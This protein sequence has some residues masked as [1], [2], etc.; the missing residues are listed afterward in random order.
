MTHLSTTDRLYAWPAR[1]RQRAIFAILAIGMSGSAIAICAPNVPA[2]S[3]SV[4]AL[5]AILL[6]VAAY[7]DCTRLLIPNWLT[8]TIAIY[9]IL[10]NGLA[11]LTHFDSATV[12]AAGMIGLQESVCGVVACFIVMLPLYCAGIGAGDLKLAVALGTLVGPWLGVS[13]IVW[14][15]ILAGAV[16]LLVLGLRQMFPFAANKLAVVVLAFIPALSRDCNGRVRSIGS[17]PVPMAPFFLAG[18]VTAFLQEVLR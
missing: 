12:N 13:I 3:L 10:L 1:F 16:V 6:C 14:T 11:S 5:V 7:T 4:A 15:H 18:A 9:G 17:Q 8:V 2:L